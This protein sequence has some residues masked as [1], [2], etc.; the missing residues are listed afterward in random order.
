VSLLWLFFKADLNF[1][2]ISHRNDD[3][4]DALDKEQQ[5]WKD[6]QVVRQS[7]L[8]YTFDTP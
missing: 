3:D 6:E 1:A 5:C 7:P 8:F 4:G 2:T